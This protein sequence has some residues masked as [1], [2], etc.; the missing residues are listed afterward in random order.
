M[1]I[2]RKKPG[3]SRV[4]SV[5][6]G[7]GGV[8][9]TNISINLSIALARKGLEVTLFDADLGLANVDVLLG[10][11]PLRNLAHVI[12]Q[13]CSLAD[14]LIEGPGGIRVVPAASGVKMMGE[15]NEMQHGALVGAF[16]ELSAT[17]DVLMIDSSAGIANSV[18]TFCAA[19]QEVLVA[20][21]N[22]PASIADAYAL[23]KVLN[24]DYRV[25]RF[26]VV[27]NMVDSRDEGHQLFKRLVRVCDSY[28]NVV[29]DL[30]AII[31][32]DLKIVKSVQKQKAVMSAYPASPASMEFKKMAD[33]VDKWPG[34]SQRQ[35]NISFFL[36]QMLATQRSDNAGA[37]L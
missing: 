27:V 12:R 20:V 37:A 11:H 14:I 5:A 29:L 4:I 33:A 1:N 31:P 22:E 7:K 6:S 8:G 32:R 17:T 16:D 30:T 21:C 18:L 35:G 9:K 3:A 34:A 28:L 25:D 36:E 2:E 23:I 19:S 10:L 15:L 13:E 24:R 26:R